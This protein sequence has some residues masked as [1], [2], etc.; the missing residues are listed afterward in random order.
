MTS[1]RKAAIAAYSQVL[2]RF[3]AAVEPEIRRRVA[4]ALVNKEAAD[5]FF[6]GNAVGRSIEDLAGDFIGVR[7]FCLGG[8]VVIC[9]FVAVVGGFFAA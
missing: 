3:G 8:F 7:P 6:D 4:V 9:L 5:T 1:D 2:V